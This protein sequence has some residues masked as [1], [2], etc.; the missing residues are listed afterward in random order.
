MEIANKS[1]QHPSWLTRILE[2]TRLRWTI[3]AIVLAVGLLGIH[4]PLT[5]RN[6]NLGRQLNA[7]RIRDGLAEQVS[8]L[9]KQYSQFEGRIPQGNDTNEWMQYLLDAVRRSP[10]KLIS[11]EPEKTRRAGP[12]QVIVMSVEVEGQ[13]KELEALIHGFESDRRIFRVEGL[14][15]VPTRAGDGKLMMQFTLAG[16]MG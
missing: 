11:L 6:A 13:F 14:T 15:I 1:T 4:V 3:T 12:F 8:T 2:P 9:R 16:L 7:E 5:E 10:V